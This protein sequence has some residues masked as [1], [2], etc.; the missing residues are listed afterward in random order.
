MK[1]YKN[2]END[3]VLPY[4]NMQ[5]IIFFKTLFFIHLPR[6]CSY[7]YSESR[8]KRTHKER[9]KTE[10]NSENR[11]RNLDLNGHRLPRKINGDESCTQKRYNILIITRKHRGNEDTCNCKAFGS[12]FPVFSVDFTFQCFQFLIRLILWNDVNPAVK[13]WEVQEFVSYYVSI[14]L[15]A[16]NC[17]KINFELG[18]SS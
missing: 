1:S 13:N 6:L 2:S 9:I 5:K 10:E 3:H 8:L 18:G 7:K 4:L 14:F 12:L 11:M 16:R 17:N 15:K